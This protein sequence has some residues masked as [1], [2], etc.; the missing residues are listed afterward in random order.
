[1]VK[2]LRT[3]IHSGVKMDHIRKRGQEQ[4]WA[5]I[6]AAFISL[7]ICPKKYSLTF[8]V[9]YLEICLSQHNL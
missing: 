7:G 4:P 1:M 8:I 5:S 3:E 9:L 6:F 2:F